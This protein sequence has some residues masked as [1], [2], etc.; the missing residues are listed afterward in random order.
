MNART[1][2]IAIALLAVTV[3]VIAGILMLGDSEPQVE[4]G[5]ELDQSS[6]FR[7][8]DTIYT[9]ETYIGMYDSCMTVAIRTASEKLGEATLPDQITGKIGSYCKCATDGARDK[10]TEVN[11]AAFSR[12]QAA[13]PAASVLKQLIADCTA[14]WLK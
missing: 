8:G 2:I 3:L 1:G 7:K 9:K 14:K 4:P 12:D 5:T 13:E 6:A 10:L 11:L